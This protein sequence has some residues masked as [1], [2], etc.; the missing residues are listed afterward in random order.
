MGRVDP[1]VDAREVL[2]GL[3]AGLGAEEQKFL[4][5]WFLTDPPL[6]DSALAANLNIDEKEIEV[7]LWKISRAMRWSDVVECQRRFTALHSE[8][9]ERG[10]A[11]WHDHAVELLHRIALDA[12]IVTYS[13]GYG[14]DVA[15]DT[16]LIQGVSA[17]VTGAGILRITL[18]ATERT[19]R[20]SVIFGHMMDAIGDQAH[21]I[22]GQWATRPGFT[23]NLDAFNAGIRN[24]LS[25]T[26]AALNTFT[27]KMAARYG[28]TE[29]TF[30]RLDVRDGDQ[31]LVGRPA[32]YTRVKVLFSKPA[33]RHPD[34]TDAGDMRSHGAMPPG[35]AAA[36]AQEGADQHSAEQDPESDPSAP[37][38]AHQPTPVP[39]SD[40]RDVERDA[41]KPSPPAA[42]IGA[43]DHRHGPMGDVAGVAVASAALGYVTSRK[44]EPGSAGDGSAEPAITPNP[45][46]RMW[47]GICG[48]MVRR[49][50]FRRQRVM[51]SLRW[52]VWFR[53]IWRLSRP[54]CVVCRSGWRQG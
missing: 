53:R 32:E 38:S 17:L 13:N 8:L 3:I 29:V 33:P 36:V 37:P 15:A 51:C 22:Q 28:Y 42:V 20:G 43:V 54:V 49:I 18:R 41:A 24:G 46:D 27:G 25:P 10:L 1:L 7:R 48:V 12:A 26:E 16:D 34:Q 39:S 50:V 52:V 31:T 44:G 40:F 19:P 45:E 6:S 9:V 2:A 4:R 11:D 21:T 14:L 30:T 5:L 35:R 47:W 23:D